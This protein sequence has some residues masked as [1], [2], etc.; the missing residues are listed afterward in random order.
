MEGEVT[1]DEEEVTADEEE[2]TADEEAVTADEEE[3]TADEEASAPHDDAP[4]N[5]ASP[6]PALTGEHMSQCICYASSIMTPVHVNITVHTW[7]SPV[8][9]CCHRL[10]ILHA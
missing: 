10:S 6:L 9:A 1:A 2:V 8:T 7:S 4:V 3:V 5:M